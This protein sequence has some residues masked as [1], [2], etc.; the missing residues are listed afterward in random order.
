L[1]QRFFLAIRNVYHDQIAELILNEG[2]DIN[3]K[4]LEE[5]TFP[6]V[7]ILARNSEVAR[8]VFQAPNINFY[9]TDNASS[10]FL[11]YAA[12]ERYRPEIKEIAVS[13]SRQAKI[14]AT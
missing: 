10:T 8:I 6:L 13:A 14:L 2:F 1:E 3:S 9:E 7:R 4:G 5:R 11:S 12:D